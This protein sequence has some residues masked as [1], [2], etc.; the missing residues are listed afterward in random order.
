MKKI[1]YP[2]LTIALFTSS[3]KIN[4]ATLENQPTE[5]VSTQMSSTDIFNYLNTNLGLTTTQKPVVKKAV[6][7]AGAETTKLNADSSKS[8]EEIK[9]AKASIVN[10]LVKKLSSSVLSEAQ[11]KKLS[12]LTGTLT[13]MFAQL[14]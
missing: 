5:I 12:G 11:S 14:K 10:T 8:A 13:T 3:Y 2:L 1:I 6:D 7:E 4:S 9:I